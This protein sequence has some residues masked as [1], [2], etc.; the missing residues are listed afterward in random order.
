MS[1]VTKPQLINGRLVAIVR[2]ADPQKAIARALELVGKNGS[3]AEFHAMLGEQA[4]TYVGIWGGGD[5]VIDEQGTVIGK[6]QLGDSYAD[7]LGIK[8]VPRPRGEA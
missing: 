1:D 6:M 8:T 2:P 3:A 4:Y 7:L 5:K